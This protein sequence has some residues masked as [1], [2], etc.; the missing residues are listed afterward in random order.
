M[1]LNELKSLFKGLTISEDRVDEE[2]YKEMVFLFSDLE[3]WNKVL[4][5]ALNPPVKP[6]GMKPDK[7]HVKAT[8]EYGAIRENQTLYKKD[9]AGQVII[10]MLWPWSDGAHI[11]LKLAQ[12]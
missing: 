10:A 11:T 3:K 4:T 6:V 1:N 2:S 8:E 7:E 12:L 5:S 9:F